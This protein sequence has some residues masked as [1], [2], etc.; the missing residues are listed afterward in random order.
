MTA[1]ATQISQIRRMVAEPTTTT[2]MD[3]DIQRY[4]ETYPVM[5][6]N[7]QLPY[8]MS[9]ATP[10]ARVVNPS[11]IASYDLHAAAADIWDEKAACLAVQYDYSAGASN[12][13]RS[14][15]YEQAQKQAR[16]HRSRAMTKTMRAVKHPK[17]PAADTLVWIANL[18]EDND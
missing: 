4:I 14:Q 9:S 17:E 3:A 15:L 13:S 2:Y 1:T 11:W 10:P 6:E 8:T 7:G 16:Y 12:F 18:P 5:D